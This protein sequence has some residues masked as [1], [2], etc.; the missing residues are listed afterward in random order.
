MSG[1]FQENGPFQISPDGQTLTEN[2]YSWNKLANVIYLE[3]PFGVGFSYKDPPVNNTYAP[4]SDNMTRDDNAEALQQFVIKFP[5]YSGRPFYIT[6]ESYGG[7]YIPTLAVK[8]TQLVDAGQLNLNFVGIAIGN[9]ILSSKNQVNSYIDLSYYRGIIGKSTIDQFKSCCPTPELTTLQYCDYAGYYLVWSGS[10]GVFVPKNFTDPTKQNCAQ[11]TWN[12]GEMNMWA[13]EGQQDVYNS[14]QTCYENASSFAQSYK[15]QEEIE[16]IRFMLSKYTSSPVVTEG[17]STFIDQGA[18]INT[19]ATDPWNGYY[20]YSDAAMTVYL[21]RPEVKSAINLTP[22][23]TNLTWQSSSSLN[24]LEQ[25]P[26]TNDL[27]ISLL[28]W[29]GSLSILL[30]NGDTDSV[31]NF[32]GDQWFVEG[33]SGLKSPNNR[34][35][36]HFSTDPNSIREIAG[37]QMRFPSS[38]TNAFID[39]ITIKGSGHLVPTDRPGPAFQMMSN[40]IGRTGNYDLATNVSVVPL[41]LTN[42]YQPPQQILCKLF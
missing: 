5:R 22:F 9:G 2:V 15:Q 24:Y 32:V 33:L 10:D 40:F 17:I 11:M 20:C 12:I 31:C 21:N 26:E 27:F 14:I 8:L 35:N 7:V 19:K 23:A 25:Y 36:W 6:G 37:S 13:S 30:Y 41:P 39:L 16:R 4:H 1:L 29:N 18:K 42:N 3:S 38:S 28:Q 34:T